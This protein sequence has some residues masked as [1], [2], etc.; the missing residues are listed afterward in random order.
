MSTL[1]LRVDAAGRP[2]E[3]MAWQAAVVMY[4]RDQVLWAAGDARLRVNGG[5]NRATGR[6]SFVDVDAIVAVRGRVAHDSM[7]ASVPLTNRE[8]F[9]RDRFTCLY[10]LQVLSDAALT[11]DHV[12]PLAQQGPDTWGNVVTACRACNQRKGAC[13][14]E[15]AGMR[16]YAVP[17]VPSRAEWLIFNNRRIRADQMEFLAAHCPK[18]SRWRE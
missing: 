7:N 15:Q 12:V 9:R 3:W 4:V 14:P 17:Y 16:L 13:T 1:I 5:V 8:L 18:G 6:Q 2:V 10:C 11:R